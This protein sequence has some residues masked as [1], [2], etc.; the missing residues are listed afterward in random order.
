MAKRCQYYVEGQC[1]EKLI[2]VL[3]DSGVSLVM[4]GKVTVFNVQQQLLNDMRL[5]TLNS[6]TTIVFVF[7]TD[8]QNK[9]VLEENIKMIKKY[10]FK[11][12]LLV[13]QNK[14]L[15]EEL[16]YSTDI[17]R[18]IDLLPCD[19]NDCFK[20]DFIKEKRLYEK[21]KYH[22]FDIAKIWSRKPTGSLAKYNNDGNKIKLK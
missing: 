20:S 17:K 15:E 9:P 18:I 14:N 21:L 13:F 7:D 10:G 11:E 8:I 1:E 6:K 19:N 12:L 5:R 16:V 3:K 22:K 4:P 2:S